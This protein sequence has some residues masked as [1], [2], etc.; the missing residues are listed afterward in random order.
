MALPVALAGST[1]RGLGMVEW[2][3]TRCP[4]VGACRR[5]Q[6]CTPPPAAVVAF[7]GLQPLEGFDVLPAPVLLIARHHHFVLLLEET[8]PPNEQACLVL[9][10]L[11]LLP[12]H[13][14]TALTLLSG[15][16]AP[17]Q[18]RQRL[19]TRVPRGRGISMQ[20]CGAVLPHLPACSTPHRA[21][22][23]TCDEG[24]EEGCRGQE[25]CGPPRGASQGAGEVPPGLTSKELLAT[26]HSIASFNRSWPP[27]LHLWHNNCRHY[28]D[29]LLLY[30][31]LP[32]PSTTT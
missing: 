14:A 28:A 16:T 29:A 8:G 6:S 27:Q 13:P 3:K 26:S 19:L 1:S 22:H 31:T 7:R 30:L 10:F 21:P 9:D 18:V 2:S 17:G 32:E 15:G 4:R 23:P 5:R 20:Q 12:R 25:P 24:K 11:P